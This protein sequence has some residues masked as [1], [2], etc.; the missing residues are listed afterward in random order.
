MLHTR[1]YLIYMDESGKNSFNDKENYIL[2]GVCIHENSWQLIDN[3][4]KKIK[5]KYFPKLDPDDV[6]FHTKAIAQGEDIFKTM[7]LDERMK[8][9]NDIYTLIS[10][11]DCTLFAVLIDKKKAYTNKFDVEHWGLKL[12]FERFCIYLEKENKKNIKKGSPT[13]CAI[14]LI[15]SIQNNYDLKIRGKLLVWIR[16]GTEYHTNKYIIEDPIFVTSSYR[17]ISQLVDSVAYCVRRKFRHSNTKLDPYF[18]DF[19][20]IIHDKFDKNDKGKVD[21]AGLKIFPK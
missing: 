9:L 17:S 21:N 19:F 16:R 12:L 18:N 2:A 5:I 10:K 15:D 20:K 4:V 3:E 14:L 13:E 8:T 1:M 7:K 11:I 6:E